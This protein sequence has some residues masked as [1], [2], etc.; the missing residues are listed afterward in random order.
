MNAGTPGGGSLRSELF[1][2]QEKRR[3]HCAT[4]RHVALITGSEIGDAARQLPPI[5]RYRSSLNAVQRAA[6]ASI[7][8]G[9]SFLT[10][11]PFSLQNQ[12]T[13]PEHDR[14]VLNL[15]RCFVT[16][17][18]SHLGRCNVRVRVK[19]VR[20]TVEPEIIA[21]LSAV[22]RD[23]RVNTG[24]TLTIAFDQDGRQEICAAVRKVAEM[25]AEGRLTRNEINSEMISSR[26]DDVDIPDPD[27][28]IGLSHQKRLA[29]YLLWQAAYSEFVF[30][31]GYWPDFDLATFK[32][33]IAEYGG[34][35]R[36]FGRIK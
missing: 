1:A 22:E 35:D 13:A 14:D 7:E 25:V 20:A 9:V 28:I 5:E 32:A 23:T 19:G 10:V 3:G 30:G 27:L 31:S 8:L 11:G 4:P 2:L 26:L 17:D 36:R 21:L 29:N 24:L 18:L 6:F 16:N 33:A 34:R 12:S 15:L